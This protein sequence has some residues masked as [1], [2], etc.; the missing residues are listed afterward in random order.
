MRKPSLEMRR[1]LAENILAFRKK[2]GI[3][4][5]DLAEIC[6]L[7]RTYVGSVERGERNATLSTLEVLARSLGVTVPELL[8]RR[9]SAEGSGER[10]RRFVEDI[11][12]SGLTIYDPIDVGDTRL[13]VPSNDLE[14][15]LDSGLRG[16][17]VAGL[18][19]RRR[20]KAIKQEVCRVLGYPVPLSFKKTRPRF[21]GQCFDT[22]AQKSNNLQISNE[23]VVPSRR[24]AIIRISKKDIVERVRV[25]GGDFIAALDPT[26]TLTGKYQARLVRGQEP[27]E[28][29][30]EWDT[31]NLR[32]LV[33]DVPARKRRAA[34]PTS[35]PS[36]GA[37]LPIQSLYKCLRNLIGS[38]FPD[39]GHDQERHRG[40]GLHRLVCKQLG[41]QEYEDDG[42]F[43]D[44]RHQLLEVKLQTSRTIDLG[45][46]CPDST[47][48]LD[49]P[50][51]LGQYVRH[52]DVRYALFYG[53]TDGKEVILTNL[54]L[55]TGEAFFNRFAQFRGK[56]V[57][58]KLQIPL[59]RDFF[60]LQTE[61]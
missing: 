21:V 10:A 17:S 60:D 49:V 11:S 56:I 41:Y 44:M 47:E 59:P 43:P 1:I 2:K 28:L 15:L 54:Y 34:K 20:S 4:Q 32:P 58:K 50:S 30:A 35:N 61:R 14:I 26:G 37:L 19:L 13:W 22:Y 53:K 57:N 52:C 12:G 3:S 18:P 7:H 9:S 24:Y 40:A 51:S 39:A 36:P 55:T 23:E 31:E 5:E 27:A 8:T 6:D 16:F 33:G 29:I 46:V 38:K 45:L 42:R 48:P 25:V